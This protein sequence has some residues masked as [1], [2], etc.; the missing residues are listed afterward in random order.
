MRKIDVMYNNLLELLTVITYEND[1]FT[2][3]HD[4][5]TS[6]Q[7]DELIE[8][9]DSI[10]SEKTE[11]NKA[12]MR[13]EFYTDFTSLLQSLDDF[14]QSFDDF[15]DFRKNEIYGIISILQKLT[16]EYGGT[17]IDLTE[18]INEADFGL[19]GLTHPISKKNFFVF[20]NINVNHSLILFSLTD[21]QDFKNFI[22]A[23]S[24]GAQILFYLL[25]KI[26]E[27]D[28]PL[29]LSKYVF[30]DAT[31][32]SKP[33]TVWATLCL[34][35]VKAGETIHQS[36]EYNLPPNFSPLSN[37]TLG[38]TYQQ[39]EDS[40]DIISEYNYQKDVLDKYL[41]IYHVFENFMYKAPL[42]NLE[43]QANGDVFSVR[44][45]KRMYDKIN[46]SELSMLKKLFEGILNLNHSTGLNY[47]T[48]IL[49][50][51]TTIIPT[52]FVDDVNL[53]ILLKKLNVVTTKGVDI[54]HNYVTNQTI[55]YFL[56]KLIYCV[57]NSIVH[58]RE[59]EF[60][61]THLN[62]ISHP[63]FADTARTL[64]EKFLIPT[65]EEIVFSLIT[66]QNNIVWYNNSKLTLWKEL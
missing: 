52:H 23:I 25:A 16:S 53:N 30:V 58:N 61:L 50:D 12:K 36:N 28:Q 20:D 41:R 64:L 65:L 55:S 9:A 14:K 60:H 62:L 31:F 46:D 27:T 10:I 43:L 63:I 2:I 1:A 66:V 39:F 3:Y 8:I 15:P 54:T 57:R 38:N 4:S 49:S 45:F 33:K 48:K 34:H 13:V 47:T 7:Q 29:N 6:V 35:I 56:P 44:D 42:V 32:I 22:D 24:S 26:G 11:I 37:I 5:K 17:T 40:I 19:L 18:N 59:T 21:K 51:W